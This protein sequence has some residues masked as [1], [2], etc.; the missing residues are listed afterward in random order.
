LIW[1]KYLETA[2]VFGK[3]VEEE[4]GAFGV[5]FSYLFTGIGANLASYLM[6]PKVVG[7][8]VGF[9]KAA[10][11]SLG[12]SGRARQTLL[13]TCNQWGISLVA[14]EPLISYTIRL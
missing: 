3:I 14:P 5:W 6:L 9:G 12:A 4:E 11:V 10:T 13:A 7:G 2:L 8:L 1:E